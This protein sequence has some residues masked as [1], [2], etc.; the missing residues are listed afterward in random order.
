MYWIIRLVSYRTKH[1]STPDIVLRVDWLHGRRR[2]ALLRNRFTDISHNLD[3]EPSIMI[4]SQW[5][6]KGAG[7][8]WSREVPSGGRQFID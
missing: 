5:R 4:Q 1:K 7:S 8:S 2:R 6:S 3:G